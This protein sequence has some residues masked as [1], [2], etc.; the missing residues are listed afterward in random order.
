MINPE[1]FLE[2]LSGRYAHEYEDAMLE[3]A[4]AIGTG[5]K[6]AL[7]AQRERLNNVINDTMGVAEGI[8]ATI[9]LQDAAALIPKEGSS[10]KA[11]APYLM[12]FATQNL[13]PKT[14]LEAAVQDLVDRVP[15]TLR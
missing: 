8:G 2:D 13:I 6:G 10:M 12:A 7:A 14:T 11:D 1:R 5:N 9:A 4:V 15:Y 3:M